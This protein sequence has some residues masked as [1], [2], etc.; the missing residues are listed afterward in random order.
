M[1][2]PDRSGIADLSLLRKRGRPHMRHYPIAGSLCA[3]FRFGITSPAARISVGISW[4]TQDRSGIRLTPHASRTY[5]ADA[6]RGSLLAV[7]SA[8]RSRDMRLV[9]GIAAAV[10]GACFAVSA[11]AEQ[12]NVELTSV[13]CAALQHV[14]TGYRVIKT[15]TIVVSIGGQSYSITPHEGDIIEPDTIMVGGTGGRSLNLMVEHQCK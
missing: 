3:V 5:R 4:L 9:P 2:A 6:R 13:D 15:T 14:P 12:P 1:T 11:F 7:G 8:Q 10:A